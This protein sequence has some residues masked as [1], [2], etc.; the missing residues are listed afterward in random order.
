M[1][2]V[3]LVVV[4]FEIIDKHSSCFWL[5]IPRPGI[6][7]VAQAVSS[8]CVCLRACVCT[9]ARGFVGKLAGTPTYSVFTIRYLSTYM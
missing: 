2:A 7:C 8:V 3:K 5:I 6:I 4:L 9:H 1:H